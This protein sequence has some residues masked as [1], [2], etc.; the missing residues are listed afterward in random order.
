MSCEKK[1]FNLTEQTYHLCIQSTKLNFDVDLGYLQ[2]GSYAPLSDKPM[3]NF[4][5]L[6]SGNNT[7]EYLGIQEEIDDITEQDIDRIIYG[8]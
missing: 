6:Q 5:V 7:F 4:N 1:C 2:G 3:I 8:G